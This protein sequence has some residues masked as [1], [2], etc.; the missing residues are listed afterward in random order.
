MGESILR[1]AT[2]S[3]KLVWTIALYSILLF[4]VYHLKYVYGFR[5]IAA[6]LNI[7]VNPISDLWLLALATVFA[8]LIKKGTGFLLSDWLNSTIERLHPKDKWAL[9]KKKGFYQL[10][11][12]L[13]YGFIIVLGLTL[14]WGSDAVPDCVIGTGKCE[15][16]IVQWP[17]ENQIP[18]VKV[19]YMIQL[20][21]KMFSL[22]NHCIVHW[23]HQEFIE[24]LLHHFMTLFLMINGYY[25]NITSIG[26]GVLMIH[27]YGDWAVN[28][29]KILRDLIPKEN[30]L[31]VLGAIT[32]PS[33]FV[34]MRCWVN[35]K[36]YIYNMALLTGLLG[37]V[38]KPFPMDSRFNEA[39][40]N[41]KMV[42]RFE[43]YMLVVLWF[44]N[45]VWSVLLL[46]VIFNGL[47]EGKGN[48]KDL[49][50]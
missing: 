25:I 43:V 4:T 12:F 10:S 2:K 39:W 48:Y 21:G 28:F 7:K 22:I 9:K 17:V 42:V 16:I 18:Y 8:G 23:D 46:N 47:I 31:K 1:I 3:L 38:G 36:C 6:E 11:S 26:V 50:I 40:E 27:D 45:L 44:M 32:I 14:G 41:A 29:V 15:D 30:K 24:I 5:V 35:L 19:F 37:D 33:M 49:K 13:W 20:G 34:W